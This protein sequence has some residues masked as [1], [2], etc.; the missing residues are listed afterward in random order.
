MGEIQWHFLFRSKPP[1]KSCGELLWRSRKAKFPTSYSYAFRMEGVFL[2]HDKRR[3]D[4]MKF[5]DVGYWIRKI[6]PYFIHHRAQR[7]A[8]CWIFFCLWKWKTLLNMV[9]NSSN[10]AHERQRGVH[11]QKI[12]R[13]LLNLTGLSENTG[14]R[15]C[16][17]MIFAIAAPACCWPTSCRWSK[18]R[19][20]SATRISARPPIFMPIS[21]TDPKYPRRRP[22]S[23]ECFFRGQM[24][25]GAAGK[26]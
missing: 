26:M 19:N 7:W 16:G 17:F 9:L 2:I 8:W 21:T 18:S 4:I 24:I 10:V 22:W 13:H 23:R 12:H 15:R 11:N 6:K 3:H 14:C 25:S 1:D 5:S 20:G